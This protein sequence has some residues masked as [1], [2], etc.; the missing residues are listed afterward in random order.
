MWQLFA[1]ICAFL[2]GISY[3]LL[4]KLAPDINQFTIDVIYGGFLVI[5]NFLVIVFTNKIEN[6]Y[7]LA[8]K[9]A[10]AG[11][12]FLY[13]LFFIS[14]SFLSMYAILEASKEQVASGFIA[15]SS[16]YPLIT[17]I[18]TYLFMN[19]TNINWKLGVPGIILS[20]VGVILLCLS[21]SNREESLPS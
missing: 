15:I 20:I 3:A 6:F 2:W 9:P 17:F 7:V 14:A 8:E 11:Y 21:K 13:I 18:I 10:N 5:T 4:T 12:L 1:I 16:V 19:Q